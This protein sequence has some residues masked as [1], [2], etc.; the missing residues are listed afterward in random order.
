MITTLP[1]S[2]L[3][4]GMSRSKRKNK[5]QHLM[6]IKLTVLSVFSTFNN[7]KNNSLKVLMI[8]TLQR[9][10]LMI[11]LLKSRRKNKCPNQMTMKRSVL[12]VCSTLELVIMKM[13]IKLLVRSTQLKNSKSTNQINQIS[14]INQ[15]LILKNKKCNSL[16]QNLRKKP[17][18]LIIRR[19]FYLTAIVRDKTIMS[20]I[21]ATAITQFHSLMQSRNLR[22]HLALRDITLKKRT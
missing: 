7:K 1:R 15:N 5:C 13:K 18:P 14:K 3:M 9:Y 8:T 11:G 17:N 12:S 16:I 19:L 6:T 2:I 20:S 4:I 21:I 10:T 22:I